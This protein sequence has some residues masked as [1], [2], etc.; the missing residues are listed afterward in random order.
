MQGS[1]RIIVQNAKVRYDF[2]I[3]RN[4]TVI[5]GNSATGKTTLIEMIR[6]YY[7]DGI[8]SGVELSCAKTCAV[9]SGRDWKPVLDTMRE[10]IVFIDEGNSFVY[11]KEFARA[12][13]QSDNYYVIVTREGLE[14]LPYSVE[15]IYGIRESGKYA[16]LKQT[17]NELYHI[18]EQQN[19]PG[20]I[21][22][23][24]V[25]VE[26]S[27]AGFDFYEGISAE[28]DWSVV[29]ANGK[30]NIFAEVVENINEEKILVIA[31][32]A[33]FGPE[34]NRM[35][36]LIQ[37]REN[38]ALY[39]PES[40][41]WLILKSG[42]LNDREVREIL[43]APQNYIDSGKY[44]SW[45]RYFTALLIEK[46]SDSYLKY[47]KKRLNPVYLQEGLKNRICRQMERIKL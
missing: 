8:S 28:A 45:E 27:N 39:L 19:L 24:K 4:L 6:E 44:L 22:P 34:M 18:Y 11:T 3:R 31:D 16:T 1:Y 2:E 13:G 30:S 25:I 38:V 14:N 15:E 7:E 23:T 5:R 12:V 46:T 29:S 42:V 17:F 10:R 9:L 47:T 20:K 26:D 36:K 41:E 37:E 33:A 32:G 21:T 35:A 43:T 40:F